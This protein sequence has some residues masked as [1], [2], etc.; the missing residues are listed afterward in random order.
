MPLDSIDNAKKKLS[1]SSDV[2]IN[3]D[4]SSW[5][6]VE[7]QY[8]IL[9]KDDV[10]PKDEATFCHNL[11]Y[12]V[13]SEKITVLEAKTIFKNKKYPVDLKSLKEKPIDQDN[14]FEG[15]VCIA[16]NFTKVEV[17]AKIYLKYKKEIFKPRFKEFYAKK[18]QF[19][20][21]ELLQ[22]S[23]ISYKSKL[24]LYYEI[25]DPEKILKITRSQEKGLYKTTINYLTK[26][27]IL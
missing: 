2:N 25:Y 4:G 23:H 19:K 6:I 18:W 15:N 11:D 9:K 3:A 12:E 7:L 1:V 24:P 8:T 16:I 22:K 20:T 17:G 14:N 5:K 27:G 26:F 10:K 21:N 13:S